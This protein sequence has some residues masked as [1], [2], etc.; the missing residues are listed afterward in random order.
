MGEDS[1]FPQRPSPSA[2]GHFSRKREKTG[3]R[4][5]KAGSPPWAVMLTLT[6]RSAA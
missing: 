2:S 4:F 6:A 5:S 1:N 3:H